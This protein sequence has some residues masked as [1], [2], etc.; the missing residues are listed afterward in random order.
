MGTLG[1]KIFE[2]YIAST[3][4]D[5]DIE[6]LLHLEYGHGKATGKRTSDGFVIL[7]GSII[8]P[9]TTKSC[10]EN[11]LKARAKYVDRINSEHVLTADILLTSP[12]AAAGFVAGASLSGNALWKDA[13]GI[14]LKQL[15][16]T[17]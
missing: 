4:N 6:P 13:N 3:I 15:E 5:D 2:P 7:K 16:T 14:S 1:H 11:V 17:T 8:N 12:S 9:T 10:P